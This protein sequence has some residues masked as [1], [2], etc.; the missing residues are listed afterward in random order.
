MTMDDDPKY[1]PCSCHGLMTMRCP[2][3]RFYETLGSGLTSDEPYRPNL[4]SRRDA[5]EI[6]ESTRTRASSPLREP[7]RAREGKRRGGGEVSSLLPPLE[8]LFEK[9]L[10][11]MEDKLCRGEF[12]TAEDRSEIYR[13][14]L[15]RLSQRRRRRRH[16][17]RG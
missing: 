2:D 7:S 17:H 4:G 13:E 1:A 15:R 5:R 9:R 10:Q 11:E 8:P 3:S 12:L 14:S 6:L 16:D